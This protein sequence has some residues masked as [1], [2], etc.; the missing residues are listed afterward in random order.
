MNLV[1]H[2]DKLYKE[3]I[4]K[5]RSDVYQVDNLIDA[6]DD[7]R[8]GITLVIR[9][10]PEVK[11]NI[12]T[13]LADLK[14]IEPEQYYYPDSDIHITLMSV[15]SCYNGFDLSQIA[16]PDYVEVINKSLI[17]EKPV[18]IEFKGITASPSCIMVQGFMNNNML[19]DIRDQLR[20]NYKSSGLQQTIDERYSIKTAHATVVRF[21]KRFTRKD[22]FIKTLESYRN[23]DFGQFTVNNVELVFNDWYQRKENVKTL[24]KFNLE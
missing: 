24:Y 5:I 17:H 3:S 19:N 11:N 4:Q 7:D 6:S 15:I 23:F 18:N 22:D 9:P 16:I 13:V 14:A 12:Q 10:E 8:R 20:I 21:R 1:E 2:Y